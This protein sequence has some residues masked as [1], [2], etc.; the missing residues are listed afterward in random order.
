MN[1]RLPRLAP[2]I[3]GLCILACLAEPLWAQRGGRG[4]GAGGRG[5]GG[6][7]R[8]FHQVELATLPEVHAD[9]KLSD[10]QQTK[11]ADLVQDFRQARR[12]GGFQRG[13][14][15]DEARDAR[16]RLFAD[17]DVQLG[18][19]LDDAQQARLRQLFVQAN[20]ATALLT[21]WGAAALSLSDEPAE[22]LR[23]TAADNR[24]TMFDAG[25]QLRDLAPDDAAAKLAELRRAADAALLAKL[26]DEQRSAWDNLQGP[27]LELDLTPL[28][29]MG[30]GGGR[31]GRGGRPATE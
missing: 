5:V 9:L 20:G 30:R 19:L 12:E 28:Q 11:V 17:Y 29:R 31:G 10:D 7:G 1:L 6:F 15:R 3:F 23:Q 2:A 13:R 8:T 21:P 22:Q 16:E 24:Q 25:P 27:A 4:R 26:T 18:D 14:Q